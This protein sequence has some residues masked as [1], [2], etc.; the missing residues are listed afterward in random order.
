MKPHNFLWCRRLHSYLEMMELR[1]DPCSECS[2]TEVASPSDV[3]LP[4]AVAA[5]DATTAAE[6][7]GCCCHGAPELTGDCP[8]SGSTCR[9][10]QN[11]SAWLRPAAVRR[12]YRE[13]SMAVHPDKCSH[14]LADKVNHVP[15]C[16]VGDGGSVH[17]PFHLLSHTRGAP[18]YMLAVQTANA[19]GPAAPLMCSRP[20]VC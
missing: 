18:S 20:S 1:A 17:D 8:S 9:Q 16:C 3:A 12:R 14:P 15:C 2:L 5:P 13:L 4:G 6:V 11:L 19:D 10:P 7:T